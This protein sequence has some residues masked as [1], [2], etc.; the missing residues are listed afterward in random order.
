VINDR[1]LNAHK[2]YLLLHTTEITPL[3]EQL[4]LLPQNLQ[5]HFYDEAALLE[6]L[7]GG[8]LR[9][10]QHVV[11]L[12]GSAL[13]ASPVP[14][15][16]GV[17]NVD[18]VIELIRN[19]FDGDQASEFDKSIL[20]HPTPYQAAFTFLLGR[21]G[22]QSANDI[23]KRAV[24]K[25]RKTIFSS[26]GPKPFVPSAGTSDEACAALD[27]DCDGWELTPGIEAIGQLAT[28]YP[29]FFG[30]AILTTNF[31]P[32]LEVAIDRSGGRHFRTVLH[33][34]GNLGQT[35]AA[36]CHIIH[37]HGYW[38]GADTLHTPRQLSQP[39]PRLKASLSSLIR[40]EYW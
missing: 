39:R 40:V 25:A 5:Q 22:Q 20:A 38:Y 4:N 23:I 30:K 3:G 16:V 10:R 36:G 7:T 1:L 29:D 12:V 11:F 34:D 37:L 15:Q 35:Q 19:E 21:R 24:W 32:L 27:S 14:G 8:V 13:A 2:I 6:R 18:G 17:P 28:A 31:D 9:S 26:N 33:R